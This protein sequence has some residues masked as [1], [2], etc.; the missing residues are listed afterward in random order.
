ML[1]CLK[2][3]QS[4]L[5]GTFGELSLTAHIFLIQISKTQ[6]LFTSAESSKGMRNGVQGDVLLCA[7]CLSAAFN[8]PDP[9][10]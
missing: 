9:V 6:C 7:F 10:I 3:L 8:L 4:N 2:H 1:F 5:N